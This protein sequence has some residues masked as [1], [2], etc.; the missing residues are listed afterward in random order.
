MSVFNKEIYRL[1]LHFLLRKT[2]NP[3]RKQQIIQHTNIAPMLALS[4]DS[5]K[6]LSSSSLPKVQEPSLSHVKHPLGHGI[7]LKLPASLS[8]LSLVNP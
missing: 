1:T 2:V 5:V 6:K 3:N 8:I 4:T 7:Q